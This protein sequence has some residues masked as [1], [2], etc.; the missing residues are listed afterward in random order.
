[1][2]GAY[3]WGWDDANNKWVKCVVNADGKLIINPT[4]F[5]ENPP[6]EDEPLKAPTSEWAFDH[7]AGN[8]SHVDDFNTHEAASGI[9]HAKYTDVEA[10]GAINNILDSAGRVTGLFN[11]YYNTFWNV[12]IFQL[13]Q[14]AGDT[15]R[16]II[17]KTANQP[18]WQ[19]SGYEE[20]VGYV[21]ATLITY[22]GVGYD[23]I[24]HQGNFQAEL[25]DYLEN[26]PTEDSTNTAPTSEWAFDHDADVAAHH[27]KY[28]DAEARASFYAGRGQLT[29]GTYTNESMDGIGQVLLNTAG[30]DITLK[31]LAD[32]IEGQMIYFFKV[33]NV[34]DVHVI[35]ASGDA[36]LGDKIYCVTAADESIQAGYYGGF[37]LIYSS[38]I[39]IVDHPLT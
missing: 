10:R 31:G 15:H 13:K 21:P 37:W 12:N 8:D 6:T 19:I 11:C 4:G 22:N 35:H 32:G 5:L 20:G 33:T 14:S 9:H 39:W 3:L 2:P 26:S 24:I 28:T 27:A 7:A 17:A 25:D 38:G 30:G 34:N 1:M 29:T 16:V 23:D 36:A 18:I